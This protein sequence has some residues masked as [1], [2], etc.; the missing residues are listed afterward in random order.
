MASVKTVFITDKNFMFQTAITIWSIIQNKRAETKLDIYIILAECEDGASTFFDK[1]KATNV[2]F[3]FVEASL[4]KYKSINQLA[5][6]SRAGL[7]KF[8]ISELIPG[9]ERLLYLDGDLI[10]RSDLTDLYS[11]DL[12]GCVIGGVKSLDM[13]YDNTEMINSGVMLID[14]KAFREGNYS[15]KMLET[16]ISLGDR[17]SMDQQTINIVLKG[18]I[19]FLPIK[20][21][22]VSEKIVGSER[23]N[24][25]IEKLN[26]LYDS[27]YGSNNEMAEKAAIIH[28]ATA[29]KPWKYTFVPFAD[30]W[31]GYFRSSPYSDIKLKRLNRIQSLIMGGVTA[32]KN[33]GIK[34]VVRRAMYLLRRRFKGNDYERW[35]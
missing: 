32:L 4:E 30:E 33:K 16:R 25:D 27:N 9:E 2:S 10:V 14:T 11:M 3:H 7:V 17:K 13:L 6:I 35:G 22:L 28:F 1:M 15:Q 23:I 20:Y 34:G 24:Y 31:Y 12:S 26:K 29:G 5:H 18:K 19:K 8:D 21:N